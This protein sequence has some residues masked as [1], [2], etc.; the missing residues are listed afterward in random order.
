MNR[1]NISI[2]NELLSDIDYQVNS[3]DFKNRSDFIGKATEFYLGFIQTG[4]AGEYLNQSVMTG[5]KQGITSIEKETMPNI[6]R[7]SVELSMLMNIIAA[8][9]GISNDELRRLR[10]DCVRAVKATN[11]RTN[12]ESANNYQNYFDDYY[13]KQDSFYDNFTGQI[14]LSEDEDY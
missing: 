9:V 2:K 3:L 8:S 1:I 4:K 12:F 14:E 13:T 10:S 11:R 7:L 6:F 5:V